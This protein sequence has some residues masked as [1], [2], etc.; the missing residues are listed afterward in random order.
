MSGITDGNV[1][2]VLRLEG[3]CVLAAVLFFYSKLDLGWST[4]A[5]YFLVPD[6]SL[7]GYLIGSKIGSASYNLA[8]SYIGALTCLVVGIALPAPA[9]LCAGMIWC[10]HI[11]FDRAF[12]FGLKYFEGFSFTH[13]GRIGRLPET[14]NKGRGH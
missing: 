12:G 1:R 9:M 4:F 8:H 3:L 11:G 14:Q 10:A 7:F 5:L 13:L 6:L 2:L